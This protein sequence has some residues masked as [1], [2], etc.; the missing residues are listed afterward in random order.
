MC[1]WGDFKKGDITV[2][3][4]GTHCMFFGGGEECIVTK[5]MIT[6]LGQFIIVPGELTL[7]A[8]TLFFLFTY[9]ATA[10]DAVLAARRTG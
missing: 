6:G 5:T 1:K 4:G 9:T 10:D 2:I 3:V 8:L 7:C